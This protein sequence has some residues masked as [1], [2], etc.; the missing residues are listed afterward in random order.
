MS[1][2]PLI[3]IMNWILEW[4][5]SVSPIQTSPNCPAPSLFSSLSDD[6]G[7]SHASFSHGFSGLGLRHGLVRVWQ[8]P[9]PCSGINRNNISWFSLW[10]FMFFCNSKSPL[11]FFCCLHSVQSNLFYCAISLRKAKLFTLYSRKLMLHTMCVLQHVSMCISLT[12][13]TF[14][15]CNNMWISPVWDQLT[16]SYHILSYLVLA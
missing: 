11:W 7:I 10:R 6:R 16:L 9:S 5:L 3:S 14:L 15:S 1:R 2:Q 12:A 8:R 4:F 13:C